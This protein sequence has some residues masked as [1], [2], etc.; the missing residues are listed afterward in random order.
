MDLTRVKFFAGAISVGVSVGFVVGTLIKRI[1]DEK[2]LEDTKENAQLEQTPYE[3]K[4]SEKQIK[5]EETSQFVDEDSERKTAQSIATSIAVGRKYTSANDRDNTDP[6]RGDAPSSAQ[7]SNEKTKTTSS[8][9][10]NTLMDETNLDGWSISFVSPSKDKLNDKRFAYILETDTCVI[11][12]NGSYIP[13]QAN[14]SVIPEN[15]KEYA[16]DLLT[17]EHTTG[18]RTVLY[19]TNTETSTTYSFSMTS[20][21]DVYPTKQS[22]KYNVRKSPLV[23]QHEESL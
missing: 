18:G 10:D 12:R 23:N 6:K 7:K 21:E 5:G 16:V 3:E 2:N 20:E 19:L 11:V 17:A 4:R 14:Q 15:V 1:I 8:K 22:K 9:G 13:L